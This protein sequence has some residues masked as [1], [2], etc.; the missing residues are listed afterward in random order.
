MSYPDLSW[1]LYQCMNCH[2][3]SDGPGWC[4]TCLALPRPLAYEPLLIAALARSHPLA[5][6]YTLHAHPSVIEAL[7]NIIGP[8]G[9]RTIAD[10]LQLAFLGD[11]DVFPEADWAPGA[12]E[13]RRNGVVALT[14]ILRDAGF[15]MDDHDEL[16]RR[17]ED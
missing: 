10:D 5:P 4:A 2:G 9:E 8:S 1:G 7:A 12:Y 14:G 15:V 6:R 17:L 11:I 16:P 13:L 3:L